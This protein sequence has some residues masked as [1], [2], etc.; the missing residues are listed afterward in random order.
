MAT[1]LAGSSGNEFWCSKHWF[2]RLWNLW[3]WAA[4]DITP[5]LVMPDCPMYGYGIT[6]AEAQRLAERLTFALNDGTVARLFAPLLPDDIERV[7]EFRDF[8]AASEGFDI[9]F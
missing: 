5:Q 4:A 3:K 1:R 2:G 8:A 6:G 9:D 7:T